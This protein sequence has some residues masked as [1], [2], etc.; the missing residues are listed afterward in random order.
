MSNFATIEQ[1]PRTLTQPDDQ[2][3]LEVMHRGRSYK[4]QLGAL[5]NYLSARVPSQPQGIAP[6]WINFPVY[7]LNGT[8]VTVNAGGRYV[9]DG[10][11]VPAG[12]R[13]LVLADLQTT[14][15]DGIPLKRFDAIIYELNRSEYEVVVGE[16]GE[17]PTTPAFDQ[18]SALLLTYVLISQD[19]AQGQAPPGNYHLKAPLQSTL[20]VGGIQAGQR[21]EAGTAWEAIFRELLIEEVPPTYQ[22]PVLW[23]SVGQVGSIL[24]NNSL[25]EI[26]TTLDLALSA[27]YNQRDGG[28]AE[29]VQFKQDGVVIQTDTQSPFAHHYTHRLTADLDLQAS[30]SYQA[31]PIKNTNLGNPSPA[32]QIEAGSRDS[33]TVTLRAVRRA[34]WDTGKPTA[35]SA[36]VRALG[37]SSLNPANNTQF[38]VNIPVGADSVAFAY[39][40]SLRPVSRVIYAEGL[41][42]DVKGAFVES[43]VSVEGAEG[44]AGIAYRVYRYVP[45]EPFPESATYTVTI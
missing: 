43:S 45:V 11:E 42:A 27:D 19:G 31:G 6:Y 25:I 40:A 21:L 23:L 3:K 5:I 39:P 4:M 16:E 34:F 35:S 13:T 2:T 8:T 38:T 26:G 12:G 15:P 22:A 10:T 36:E 29:Q 1:I 37:N 44:F 28:Q 33:N 30:V 17:R 18:R 7:E 41:N 24:P 9:Q 32:G 14:G 20:Q